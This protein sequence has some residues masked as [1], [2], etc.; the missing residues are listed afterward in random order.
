MLILW[1]RLVVATSPKVCLPPLPMHFH[2]GHC[3][4]PLA[5]LALHPPLLSPPSP[6]SSAC[7]E[8]ARRSLWSGIGPP[9]RRCWPSLP[10][11]LDLGMSS[12]P[13]LMRPTSISPSPSI[14][15][16][17]IYAKCTFLEPNP[18][19]NHFPRRPRRHRHCPRR[20]VVH[21]PSQTNLMSV[22]GQGSCGPATCWEALWRAARSKRLT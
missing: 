4:P 1:I 7:V 21:R 18:Q 22:R 6:P 20:R 16:S 14:A 3:I 10:A 8:R 15:E 2:P 11:S 5:P 17:K 19:V 9:A 12:E 13:R